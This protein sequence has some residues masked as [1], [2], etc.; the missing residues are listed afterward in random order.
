MRGWGFFDSYTQNSQF[1]TIYNQNYSLLQMVTK[2]VSFFIVLMA[3][4]MMFRFY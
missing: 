4:A 3:T 1:F 2:F